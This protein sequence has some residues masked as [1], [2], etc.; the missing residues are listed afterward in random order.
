MSLGTDTGGS[1]EIP[2]SFCGVVGLKPTYGRISRYGVVPLS[3][4]L[5]HVGCVNK[6]C[7][8][9]GSCIG[10]YSWMGSI[11]LKASVRQ[12]SPQSL[13][14]LSKDSKMKNFMSEYQQVIFLM[15]LHPEVE[16]LFSDFIE[17]SKNWRTIVITMRDLHNTDKYHRCWR[18]VGLQKPHKYTKDG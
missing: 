1:I 5:D 11:R 9:R 6:E 18:D 13:R 12:A 2:S 15:F 4:S 14:K 3:P 7:M 17:E 8:G 10:M 16:R